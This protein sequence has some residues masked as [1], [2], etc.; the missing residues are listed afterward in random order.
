MEY[1]FS[2]FSDE[3]FVD[4]VLG[5]ANVFVNLHKACGEAHNP[6]VFRVAK[7]LSAGRLVLS[8]RAHPDDEIE[9]AGMVTFLPNVSEIATAFERIV[10]GGDWRRRADEASARFRKRFQPRAVFRRANV[11]AD[12]QRDDMWARRE[13]RRG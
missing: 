3:A 5:R 7:L 2:A 6:V 9:Y 1:T 13:S 10:A 12:L 11:Y 8:E 4:R